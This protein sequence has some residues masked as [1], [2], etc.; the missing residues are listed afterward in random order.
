MSDYL[1]EEMKAAVEV[2]RMA[3]DIMREHFDN[4][5][6]TEYKSDGSPVTIADKKINSMVIKEMS[7]RF[8]A[9]GIIGE[10]ESNSDYGMGTKWF[11]DPIDGTLAY[12]WGVPTSMFSLALVIDG[13][14]K[15]GVTY[16][17]YQ[18]K[19][20]TAIDGQGSFCNGK[21]IHVSDTELEQGIVATTADTKRISKG[22][23]YIQKLGSANTHLATFSGAV[24]KAMHVAN[25]RFVGYI[26]E[27]LNAHDIAA[28]QV[29]VEE[30]GGKVTG[31]D[32]QP[33][34]FSKPLKGAV[35]SNGKVHEDLLKL[36]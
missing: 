29:I 26:E 3:G 32:G 8:M 24:Y 18:N 30:A 4:D 1:A 11:C 28:A 6:R 17:P 20:Y 7:S 16:D 25:G 21:K 22:V 12:T 15:L 35:V 33:L 36:I 23:N 5:Q 31:I 34:D 9:Y 10:E 19:M 2:A 13:K 14:A 27:M